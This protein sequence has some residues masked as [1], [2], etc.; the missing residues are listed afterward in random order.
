MIKNGLQFQ[1]QVSFLKEGEKFIA[2]SPALDVSTSGDSLDQVKKR[3]EEL[4][5]SFFEECVQMGTLED[6][7][8]DLGWQ[9]KTDPSSSG[10][11]WIP[12]TI[13]GQES[14]QVNIHL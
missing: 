11:N 7:L 10:G 2:Y 1:L 8:G 6:V 3:F 4:S 14:H 5:A 12:P 9:K 13:I